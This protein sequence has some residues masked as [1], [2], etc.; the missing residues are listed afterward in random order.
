MT[1]RLHTVCGIMAMLAISFNACSKK[2]DADPSGN[3]QETPAPEPGE[4]GQMQFEAVFSEAFPASRA[5]LDNLAPVW[6]EGDKINLFGAEGLNRDLILKSIDG[7]KAVFEGEAEGDGPYAAVYPYSENAAYVDG[8]IIA[9]IPASQKLAGSKVAPGALLNVAY[10]AKASSKGKASLSFINVCS[11][12]DVAL[13]D[14]NITSVA[15]FS[16]DGSPLAGKV[17][18]D[19]STGE[20]TLLEGTDCIT[21]TPEG[22]TFNTGRAYVSVLPGNYDDLVLIYSFKGEVRKAEWIPEGSVA[23]ARSKTL[24]LGEV[25]ELI[26][27]YFIANA[28]DLKAWK[29]DKANWS[30]EGDVVNIIGDINLNDE[31]WEPLE[32]T[33]PGTL[34]GNGHKISHFHVDMQNGKFAG[35]FSKSYAKAVNNLIFGSEDGKTYDGSSYIKLD[36]RLTSE[37][38]TYAGI[39][40]YTSASANVKGV[41]N[42]VPITVASTNAFKSRA[43]GIFAWIEGGGMNLEDCVNH[44]SIT[45]GNHPSSAAYVTAGGILGGVNGAAVAIKNCTNYGNVVSNNV[46]SRNIGGIIGMTYSAT[47]SLQLE[48][49]VNEGEVKIQTPAGTAQAGSMRT[50]GIGGSI[51]SK[52]GAT[53]LNVKN[54]TNRGKVLAEAMHMNFVGG[55]VG[56]ALGASIDGC[57]NEGEV[58]IDHSKNPTTHLQ[59]VG[60]ILGAA[61]YSSGYGENTLTNNE[62]KGKVTLRAVSSGHTAAP[63]S[64]TT[65]YGSNAGGIVGLS[66]ELSIMASNSNSGEVDA[67]NA[68]E[69]SNSLYPASI[70][71]GGILGYDY[72]AIGNFLGN[73][74]DATVSAKTTKS[75]SVPS[76]A[77][78]GGVAGHL[79]ASI[80]TDGTGGGKVSASTADAGGT[81]F[82]GSIVGRNDGSI[83]FC[84]YGGQVNGAAA[85]AANT[86]GSGDAPGQASE[87]G[88][89]GPQNREFNVSLTEAGFPG[90]DYNAKALVV[91]TGN[92]AVTVTMQNLDW[93]S[94]NGIPSEIEA[95]KTS[96]LS[97]VPA[98]GNVFEKREGYLIFK[99]KTSG[100]EKSVKITQGNLYTAVDGFPAKWYIHT[101]N[102]YA[103][104]DEGR[105]WAREG[106]A[107]TTTYDTSSNSPDSGPGFGYISAT[108]AEKG[109][110]VCTPDASSSAHTLCLA[111]V[112]END[113]MNFSVPVVS[114]PAGTA[115]DFMLTI[116]NTSNSTPKY[117]LFEYWDG[118]SWK[119]VPRYTAE[120]DG[121]TRYSFTL[122]HL[123]SYNYTTFIESFNLPYKVE[124][125]FVKMRIRAV[126]PYNCNGAA[127]VR[128]AG[129]KVFVV[130]TSSPWVGCVI[131]AYPDAPAIKDN[132]KLMQVGNSQ[133]FCYG[134][135]FFLK[136]LCSAG[137][138]RTDVRIHLKGSM[139]LKDHLQNVIFSQN[140]IN[141]GGYDKAVLQDG[142]YY[143]AVSGY[144]D[145]GI[146][147]GRTITYEIGDYLRY[148]KDITAVMREKSPSCDIVLENLW[149]FS[150][151]KLNNWLGFKDAKQPDNWTGTAEEWNATTG[152]QKMD[153]Y[154]WKGGTEIATADPNVNW[155][156]PIGKAYTNARDNHGFGATYNYL[157]WTDNYH[158]GRYGMYL[159]ACVNYLILFGDPFDNAGNNRH[160]DCDIPHD[161]AVELRKAAEEIVFGPNRNDPSVR[162]TFHFHQK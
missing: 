41:V 38:W 14:N 93:L 2:E 63:S 70:C 86:V 147:N 12:I 160:F 40:T 28:A 94:D 133:T 39:F 119:G 60:G 62:N 108:S 142:T 50:G 27:G 22:E 141:E 55:I 15:I 82:A 31:A 35:F 18:I 158:G 111:N 114:L 150:Y 143:H 96:V 145:T 137:G 33:Y 102:T 153:W 81:A 159:K 135:A 83:V 129:A 120:E 99:E 85:T 130:A 154:Q 136:Q 57:V 89:S 68:F 97:L 78:A 30:A 32:D 101:S 65:F 10:T 61:G 5:T 69:A 37:S 58:A 107:T 90:T 139:G 134:S 42:F 140:I 6:E 4:L 113:C 127:L 71:A 144:G 66:T 115:V 52:S 53:P 146:V 72:A 51:A 128:T 20:A 151:K 91:L 149:S 126:G 7:G 67:E 87:I 74:S 9:E 84:S 44:G 11:V 116:A 48:G 155:L 24:Q 162:E 88:G 64:K 29:A 121:K 148:T 21:L 80:L 76:Q 112:G 98:S 54:C 157:N 19:P 56:Q 104:N 16:K 45:I 59:A 75:T 106:I 110:L 79:G 23:L 109:K 123:S 47:P 43:G 73:V 132:V 1:I 49:C 138:H 118:S 13:E 117:W 103:N 125:D 36:C 105:K 26:K 156:S 3:G 46:N 17:S 34:E 124:N 95:G 152:W 161:I 77:F 25:N 92:E 100:T 8:K 122:L 131:A